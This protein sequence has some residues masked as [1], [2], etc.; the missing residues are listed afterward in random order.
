[1]NTLSVVVPI[2]NGEEYIRDT[3]EQINSA[4]FKPTEIIL[5]NDGSKDHSLAI[6][7]EMEES[8][9]NVIVVDQKNGGIMAARNKGIDTATGE[10][11]CFCDQDDYV[12]ADMYQK[13]MKEFEE[14]ETDIVMVSTGAIVNGEKICYEQ[15]QDG[16]YDK[17]GIEAELLYAFLFRGYKKPDRKKGLVINS[18]IWKCVIRKGLLEDYHIRFTRFI[19]YEDDFIMMANLLCC[20]NKIRLM[21]Y[22]GY[23]W[24]VNPKSE[25]HRDVYIEKYADKVNELREYMRKLL[26]REGLQQNIVDIYLEQFIFQKTIDLVENVYSRANVSDRECKKQEV[27][28]YIERFRIFDLHPDDIDPLPNFYRLRIL[29]HCIK[30]KNTGW[31]IAC[32]RGFLRI[33]KK[34]HGSKTIMSA[35]NSKK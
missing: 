9:D 15:F 27:E 20:A 32:M 35:L 24:Y 25:S 29:Y 8:Y 30:K 7:R 17:G 14:T 34:I 19:N 16:A 12:D 28:C 11:I 6:C 13:V 4:N 21:S 3:V 10:Y 22:V 26:T 23:Y 33:E 31:L 18:T 2:Y 1:M 5:V